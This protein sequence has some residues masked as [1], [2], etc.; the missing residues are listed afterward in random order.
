MRTAAFELP[1]YLQ[2]FV[3]LDTPLESIAHVGLHEYG[4]IAAGGL[5]HLIHRHLHE[6]HAILQRAAVH[7]LAVV[8]IGRQELTEQ[9]AMPRMHLHG[10]ESRLTGEAH[11]MSER[12]CH[13]LYLTGPHTAH[14]SGRV[15]IQ[16]AGSRYG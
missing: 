15:D 8:G 7:V 2:P 14:E 3:Q 16:S 1:G 6:T 4:H 12:L 5:H 9:I 10:I 11:G 13:L